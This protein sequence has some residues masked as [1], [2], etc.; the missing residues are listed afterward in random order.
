MSRTRLA[1]D[2][3]S[4]SARFVEVSVLPSSATALDDQYALDAAILLER[5][6]ASP[7]G[8]GTVRP[9]RLADPG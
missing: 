6:G 5:G 7:P 9:R 4:V 8:A 3:L 1:Y 2:W